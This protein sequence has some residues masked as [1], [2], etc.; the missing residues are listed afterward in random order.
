MASI[1]ERTFAASGSMNIGGGNHFF[2]LDCSTAVE[3]IFY[4]GGRE[5]EK[6]ASAEQGLSVTFDAVPDGMAFDNAVIT[7]A[8]A[9][10]LRT[11]TGLQKLDFNRF[12]G[13]VEIESSATRTAVA[14]ATKTNETYVIAARA[15]RKNLIVQHSDDSAGTAVYTGGANATGIKLLPGMDTGDMYKDFAGALTVYAAGVCKIN[16][17]EIY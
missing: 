13:V 15:G 12:S 16:Y 10:Y 2:L 1:I 8:V 6:I 7:T 11:A 4:K 9:Q 3:V 14:Q 5:I 17:E